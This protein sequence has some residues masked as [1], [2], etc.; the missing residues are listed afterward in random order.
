M[1]TIEWSVIINRPSE[2]IWKYM[3]N[4]EE[5]TPKWDRGVL[6][7]RITSDGPLGVGTTIETRRQFLGLVRV[8]KIQISEWQ[9]PR[10]VA[11]Q[12]KLGQATASQRYRLESIENGTRFTV[13]A[14]LDFVGWW[15][16]IVPILAPMLKRD[17]QEDLANL[18]RILEN[19]PPEQPAR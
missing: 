1:R 13:T 11:F 9:P 8:G 16:W 14:S 10:T 15:K 6:A 7:A 18:K 3:S 19:I 5:N 2:L 17:E 12:M 4:I